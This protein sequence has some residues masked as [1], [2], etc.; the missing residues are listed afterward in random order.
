MDPH[1][2]R[3][4]SL[5]DHLH[6]AERHSM[7]ALDKCY[8]IE[9]TTRPIFFRLALARAQSLLIKLHNKELKNK[10]EGV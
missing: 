1:A 8:T 10:H 3:S 4:L 9:G 6:R 7:M 2:D 5:K